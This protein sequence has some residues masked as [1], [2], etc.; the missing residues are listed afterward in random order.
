MESPRIGTS[1][2]TAEPLPRDDEAATLQRRP[3]RRALQQKRPLVKPCLPMS[4]R[5]ATGERL[6]RAARELWDR[7]E[8]FLTP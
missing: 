6:V 4:V 1:V 5:Q 8:A 2:G 7:V 3:P